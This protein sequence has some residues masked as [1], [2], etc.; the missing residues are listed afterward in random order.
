MNVLTAVVHI[1]SM[2]CE[3][4]KL[5][6]TEVQ[7]KMNTSDKIPST[8]FKITCDR[9]RFPKGFTF[10]KAFLLWHFFGTPCI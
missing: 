5:V 1:L 2:S 6:Q 4:P 3:T 9:D 7:L 10:P 8:C